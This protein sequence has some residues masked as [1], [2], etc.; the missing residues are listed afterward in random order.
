M[1]TSA[2]PAVS[3]TATL[4]NRQERPY[5]LFRSNGHG[6]FTDISS[7][8][9]GGD[10]VVVRSVAHADFKGHC[11]PVLY[12]TNMGWVSN[13]GEDAGFSGTAANGATL[14]NHRSCGYGQLP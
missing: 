13:V 2:S 4:A 6:N 10:W 12:L 11:C 9:G 5:L 14:A 7:I 3:W 8:G 1:E